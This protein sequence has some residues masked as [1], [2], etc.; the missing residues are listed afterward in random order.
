MNKENI[1]RFCTSLA[2]L[3]VMEKNGVI[4]HAEYLKAEGYLAKKILYQ[5][6]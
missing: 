4:T 3:K 2:P 6:R 5:K 1:I